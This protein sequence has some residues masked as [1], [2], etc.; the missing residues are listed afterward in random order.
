MKQREDRG[1]KRVKKCKKKQRERREND[2]RSDFFQMAGRET[3][4]EVEE[5]EIVNQVQ[6]KRM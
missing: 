4:S 5:G 1:T 3:Q 2:M 6:S